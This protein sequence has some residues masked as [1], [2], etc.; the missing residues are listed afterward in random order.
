M[1]DLERMGKELKCPIWYQYYHSSLSSSSII[2]L[3]FRFHSLC[4]VHAVGVCSI[5]QFRLPA[6]ISSASKF[7]LHIL[8]N[9]L[10]VFDVL[11]SKTTL[12]NPNVILY[13]A[14]VYLSQ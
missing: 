11:F 8:S 14:H 2:P 10:F 9:S 5:P 13:S 4:I 1:G 7:A 3:L 12:I 6:I